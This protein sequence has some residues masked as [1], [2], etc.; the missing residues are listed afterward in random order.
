MDVDQ[1]RMILTGFRRRFV[2]CNPIDFDRV[3]QAV[4]SAG[5]GEVQV[6]KSIFVRP[7]Q[8]IIIE[9]PNREIIDLNPLMSVP[10]FESQTL[11]DIWKDQ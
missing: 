1:L 6:K 10:P 9:E 8:A 4:R 7:G 5:Y 3:Q 2:I 11:A